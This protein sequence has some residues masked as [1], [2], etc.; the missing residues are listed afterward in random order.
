MYAR[1]PDPRA[2]RR[3]TAERLPTDGGDRAEPQRVVPGQELQ[4]A[5][6]RF[7]D[8][9]V[10]GPCRRTIHVAAA[11]ALVPSMPEGG[12]VLLLGSRTSTGSPGKSPVRGNQGCNGARPDVNG[13]DRHPDA[14]R[15]RPG[16]QPAADACL[17][18]C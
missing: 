10:A 4:V 14:E 12:R 16:G 2:A 1:R 15:S 11:N 9:G 3:A 13:P 6:G 18:A 8:A 7:P 17:G 5:A